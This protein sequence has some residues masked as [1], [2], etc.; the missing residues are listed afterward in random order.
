MGV[1]VRRSAMRAVL[2]AFLLLA[3]PAILWAQAGTAT[4]SGTVR[5]TQ[6]AVLPGA[7]ITITQ[8]STGAVRSTVTNETGSYSMPGLPPGEYVLKIELPS[9]SPYI[10]ENVLLRRRRGSR[11]HQSREQRGNDRR[12]P[13]DRGEEAHDTRWREV[14]SHR[15]GDV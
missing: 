12:G 8:T 11:G 6:G 9:F 3:L 1:F 10:R 5:D 2:P 7:T 15:H 14:C 4:V 13:L